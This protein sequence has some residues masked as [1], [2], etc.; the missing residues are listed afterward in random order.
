MENKIGNIT[1][2]ITN[3]CNYLCTHCSF[4]S[5]IKKIEE[6]S[7]QEWIDFLKEAREGENQ[8]LDISGGEPTLRKD[9][10]K[11]VKSGV[12]LG[13]KVK[14]LTNGAYLTDNLLQE[15]KI[16]GLESIAISLDGS[17]S[18][19]HNAIRKKGEEEFNLTLEKIKLV[20]D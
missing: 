10:Q 4:D 3:R 8:G 18:S 2:N 19:T 15:L 13:Y 1:V 7:T 16:S 12:S 14:L 11:I 17:N 9:L 5:G 6:C 20:K